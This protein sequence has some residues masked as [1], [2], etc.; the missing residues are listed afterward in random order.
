MKLNKWRIQEKSR[1]SNRDPHKIPV[2]GDTELA[3]Q[4]DFV[5][6]GSLQ[7]TVLC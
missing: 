1:I 6:L 2:F 3:N 7:P 5:V 4:L